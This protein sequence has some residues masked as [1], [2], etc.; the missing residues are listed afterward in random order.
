MAESNVSWIKENPENIKKK[1]IE[2]AKQNVPIEK[3][4]IALRDEHGIPSV[5][6]FGLRVKKILKEE[7]IYENNEMEHAQRRI[8]NSKKH[9][10][11]NNHDYSSKQ[12]IARRVSRL[13]KIR[14][15]NRK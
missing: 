1:V 4:G 6:V 2:L 12:S 11:K 5:K 8:E 14:K 13:N 10:S 15:Y 3:I 9:F 7:N